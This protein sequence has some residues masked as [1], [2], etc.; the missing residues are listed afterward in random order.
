MHVIYF[1]NALA[2][3]A[4]YLKAGT[5]QLVLA[6]MEAGWADPSLLLDDPLSA[7]WDVSRDLSL[8]RPLALAGRWQRASAVE[9][10][11]RLADLAGEFVAD[12]GAE[13]IVPGAGEIVACWQDTL[14]MVDK[15]DLGALARRCDWA[16]KYL[17]L[18]RQMGRRGL[19]WQS[20]E[21]KALDLRYASLDPGEGL[22]LQLAK[23]GQVEAMPGEAAIA[24]CMSEPPDDTRAYLRAHLLRR[25]GEQVSDIDWDRIRFRHAGERYRGPSSWLGMPDPAGWGKEVSD[26]VLARCSTA[27]EFI[28]AVGEPEAPAPTRGSGLSFDGWGQR[29]RSY[30][31]PL[32]QDW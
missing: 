20:A 15:R 12:G 25:L 17:V 5:T 3:V 9:V 8:H 23:A 30:L 27:R 26:P 1:D 28:E 10:Q 18:Q 13:E 21:V 22:F 24:L 14:D 29:T 2:P 4:N 31:V 6:L 7:A 19:S 16:L 11:R 32:S